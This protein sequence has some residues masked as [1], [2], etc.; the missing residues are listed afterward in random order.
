MQTTNTAYTVSK[1]PALPDRIRADSQS[2]FRNVHLIH[3]SF[4]DQYIDRQ[5]GAIFSSNGYALTLTHTH[6][7][8]WP[9]TSTTTSPETFTF[10][11]PY[12]SK[13]ASDPLPLATLVSPSTSS[14][15]P[16]LL[17]VMPISGKIAYWESISSA[18]TLDFIRQQRTGVEDAIHG[19]F[20]GEYV[21][22]LVYAESAGFMLAFSTGRLA[23][24][25]VR[26]S[27][28]RPAISV[29]FLRSG[30]GSS[31][32]GNRVIATSSNLC[33]PLP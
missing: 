21:V 4:T 22:E 9:Y 5:H 30:L 14:E 3:G 27:H 12:P 15:E 7:I 1:L 32:G 24:M 33:T 8:V 2:T 6:A 20:S 17:V 23:Y 18:A 29:Q 26:D 13:H 10:A 19:M 25:S 31:G 11:L 16:G 28:G